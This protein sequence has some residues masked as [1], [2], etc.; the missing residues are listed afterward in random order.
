[1][2]KK[3]QKKRV[4]GDKRKDGKVFWRYQ[5]GRK[6]REYWV[7]ANDYLLKQ[8]QTSIANYVRRSKKSGTNCDIDM[9]WLLKRYKKGKCEATGLPFNTKGSF[10]THLQ[11]HPFAPSVDKIQPSKGYTKK[12]CR[13]VC[14]IYNQAKATFTEKTLLKMAEALVLTKS[15]NRLTS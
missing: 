6:T 1:M 3:P 9:D 11:I 13:M 4:R 2:N 8:M 14:W 7:T 12:N 15:N 10:N 5:K